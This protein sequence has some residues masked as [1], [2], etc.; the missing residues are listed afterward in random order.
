MYELTGRLVLI[1]DSKAII[2]LP[3]RNYGYTKFIYTDVELDQ[4]QLISFRACKNLCFISG[5]FSFSGNQQK[6]FGSEYQ[7]NSKMISFKM[8]LD[9]SLITKNRRLFSD[10]RKLD[11]LFT[12]TSEKNDGRYPP[13]FFFEFGQEQ[14]EEEHVLGEKPQGEM[15]EEGACDRTDVDERRDRDRG[16][17]IHLSLSLFSLSPRRRRAT[18]PRAV[19]AA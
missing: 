8:G 3:R 9:E 5:T 17:T 2:H 4:G 13:T 18:A 19:T 10:L 11:E 14:K 6:D 12:S 16:L 1:N 15:G 7:I